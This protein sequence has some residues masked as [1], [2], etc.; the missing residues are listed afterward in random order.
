MVCPSSAVEPGAS[1]KKALSLH[2]WVTIQDTNMA[3]GFRAGQTPEA[4]LPQQSG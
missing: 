1:E 4:L 3:A 2:L